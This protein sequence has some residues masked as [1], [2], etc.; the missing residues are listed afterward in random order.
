MDEI[1]ALTGFV[2]GLAP[3]SAAVWMMLLHTYKTLAASADVQ[4]LT[5]RLSKNQVAAAQT[6]CH[7][8]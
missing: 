5:D 7:S 4:A 8:A 3:A 2:L 6:P 1:V